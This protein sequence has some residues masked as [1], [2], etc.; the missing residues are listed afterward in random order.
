M[1]N[2]LLEEF[3]QYMGLDDFKLDE[4]NETLLVFDEKLPVLLHF[5]FEK[6]LLTLDADL[7]RPG[8]QNKIQLMET[9]MEAANMWRELDIWFSIQPDS[10]AIHVH[11][12]AVLGSFPEFQQT[13]ESFVEVANHWLRL[14]NLDPSAVSEKAAAEKI[15]NPGPMSGIPV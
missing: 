9:L 13:L 10:K 1:K 8:Q 4:N 2:T 14:I 12:R 15:R 5:D 7:G 11:R 3:S 6:A